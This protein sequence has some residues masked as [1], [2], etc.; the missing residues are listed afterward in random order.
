[1]SEDQLPKQAD[2]ALVLIVCCSYNGAH[3]TITCEVLRCLQFPTGEAPDNA[4][5][6]DDAL[7]DAISKNLQERFSNVNF[8]VFGTGN[9]QWGATY[10]KIPKK[11]DA[12]LAALGGH[13]FFD[14]GFGVR[15]FSIVS[16]FKL[17]MFVGCCC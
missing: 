17:T 4:L 14:M 10:Q 5:S 6:F 8:A 7:D 2:K 3:S 15:F 11:I 13:R 12:T 16:H 9:K 1:M